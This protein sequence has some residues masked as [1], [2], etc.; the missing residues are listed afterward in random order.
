MNSDR[1]WVHARSSPRAATI[2][3]LEQRLQCSI[4]VAAAPAALGEVS[5]YTNPLEVKLADPAILD[6]RRGTSRYYLSGTG[7]ARFVSDDLVNWRREGNWADLGGTP[8]S[9]VWASEV[10]E[11][12]VPG[13]GLQFF[14][15]FS[16]IKEGSDQRVIGVA[17]AASPD[18]PF[19]VVGEVPL[20]PSRGWIDPHVLVVGKR[21]YLYV[22]PD[23]D[24][25][26]DGH[27]RITVAQ[28]GREMISLTTQPQVIVEQSEAWESTWIEGAAVMRQGKYYYLTY[29]SNCY[30]GE[31]Y[32]VGVATSRKPE[33]PF[34]KDARRADPPTARRER[35]GQLRPH[36]PRP[37]RV[38]PRAPRPRA[39]HGLSTRT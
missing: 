18:D 39:V 16:A 4:S 14:Y 34:V 29:S 30:C 15:Y 27:S 35:P 11:R 7:S 36:R 31:R 19:A 3:R 10:V 26:P 5:A 25:N 17:R 32:A 13:L 24:S 6:T 23:L 38:R 2:E 37:Q 20:D 8:Y 28:L 1:R 9:N 12:K 22:T 33:G 21:S